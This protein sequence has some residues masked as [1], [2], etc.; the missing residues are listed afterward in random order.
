MI[1][2]FT[3]TSQFHQWNQFEQKPQ[4]GFNTSPRIFNLSQNPKLI[5]LTII[6]QEYINIATK[7]IDQF[8]KIRLDTSKTP[9]Y[10]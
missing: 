4:I 6:Y 7:P 1:N 9:I 3:T 2:Y 5:K 8:H 10:A